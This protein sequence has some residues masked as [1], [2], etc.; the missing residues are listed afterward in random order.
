MKITE[1]IINL[2]QTG[3]FI[4]PTFSGY[5]NHIYFLQFVFLLMAEFKAYNYYYKN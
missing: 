1:I 4:K 5:K 3:K 2:D